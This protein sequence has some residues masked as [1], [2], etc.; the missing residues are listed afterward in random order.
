[1]YAP[2]GRTPAEPTPAKKRSREDLNLKEKQRMLR[3]NERIAQLKALLLEAGVHTKKNKQAVLDNTAHY[4]AQLRGD[5]RIG[6]QQ[7]ERAEQQARAQG[8]ANSARLG[9]LLRSCFERNAT[10]R[11]VL[12]AAA[13]T[14]AFNAAFAA[15]TGLAEAALRKK[16]TLRPYL[17]ADERQFAAVVQKVLAT[18]QTVSVV[19]KAGKGPA[20]TLVAAAV[21]DDSD[22]V[23]NIEL[24]LVPVETDHVPVKRQKTKVLHGQENAEVNSVAGGGQL[25]DE[26]EVIVQL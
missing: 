25:K 26:P 15:R 10:P 17:C 18:K 3:L 11:V 1:M 22:Q 19:V 20:V 13:R 16:E 12:D 14:V 6:Q 24:S 5:L 2:S 21:T 8:P 7:A 9:R 4:I 23:V